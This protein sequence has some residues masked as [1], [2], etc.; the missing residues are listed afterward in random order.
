VKLI[1]LVLYWYWQGETMCVTER[2]ELI[3]TNIDTIT[4]HRDILP[5]DM[6]PIIRKEIIEKRNLWI[7]THK[8]P[9]DERS[10]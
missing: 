4:V 3:P 5:A 10:T 6:N 1:V 9:R 2:P 7:K 8:C